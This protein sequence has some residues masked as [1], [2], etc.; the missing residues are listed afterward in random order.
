[1]PTT[2]EFYIHDQGKAVKNFNSFTIQL[3]ITEIMLLMV[4]S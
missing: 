2:R 4:P 3:L 1:M